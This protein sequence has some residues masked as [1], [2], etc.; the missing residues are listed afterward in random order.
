MQLKEQGYS[1]LDLGSDEHDLALRD[2][3]LGSSQQKEIYRLKE[4]LEHAH[5]ELETLKLT[6]GIL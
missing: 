1:D 5:S 2:I 4:Q 3:D 6:V